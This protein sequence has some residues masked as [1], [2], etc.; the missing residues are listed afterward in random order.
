MTILSH[1]NQE[2]WV[3]HPYY[4]GM[5]VS[6]F[7]RIK[8]P[9]TYVPMPKGGMRKYTTK[10]I[11]RTITKSSK[12]AKH[13]YYGIMNRRLGNL[14][15]H[16]LVCETFHGLK[17]FDKAVVIHKDEN[18]LNNNKDN[19]KWGTM[20]ENLNSPKFIEYCK[21]RTGENSNIFKNKRNK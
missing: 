3:N 20:K 2:E 11:L 10:P 14:K 13:K 17:P 8:M 5:F 7:G 16:R 1:S 18:A 15:V 6:S 12:N 4:E 21:S 19:L 9:E